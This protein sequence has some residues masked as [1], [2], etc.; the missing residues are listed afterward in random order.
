MRG[1][2]DGDSGSSSGSPMALPAAEVDRL[3]CSLSE[4]VSRI[5]PFWLSQEREDLVQSALV[6]VVGLLGEGEKREMNSTYLWRTAY[7]V[8][9]DEIRR[10]RWKHERSMDGETHA[11]DGPDRAVDPEKAALS[12]EVSAHV[13]DCLRGLEKSRRRA[14]I[15]RLAGYGHDDAAA[16]LGMTMKQIANY[17]HRG[18]SELRQCLRS[19][20]LSA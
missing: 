13:R 5:C 9:L 18:M 4:A 15:L 2:P 14:V 16:R 8:T 7:S 3:Q 10:A 19:K 20:G 17:V 11:V 12:R 1:E 6:R